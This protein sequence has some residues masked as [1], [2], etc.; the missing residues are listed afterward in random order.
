ML[1]QVTVEL[2]DR[3]NPESLLSKIAERA[4]ALVNA[5]HGFIFLSEGQLLVLRA[6][7]GGFAHNIGRSEPSPGS[8][9]L[10]QVWLSGESFAAENY[11]AW[12]FHDPDYDN[13]RLVAIAGVPIRAAGNMAGVLEVANTDHSRS[14]S[15][16]EIGILERFALLASLVLDNTQLFSG[17]Q[18]ELSERAQAEMQLRQANAQLETQMKQIKGLQMILREQAIRDPL[19]GLYNRRYLA[20][21][22]DREL[23]RAAREGYPVGFVMLDIDH[24][25][26]VNDR[27]GHEVGDLVLRRLS[28]LVQEQTRIGGI[29]CRY[30]GEEILSILPNTTA[31][32]AFQIAER[33]RLAFMGLDMS[34]EKGPVTVTIS[35]GIS[36][37]PVHGVA[38]NELIILA[39]KAM[40]QAKAAGRNRVVIWDSAS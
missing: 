21:T 3:P 25:K 24:F 31:E 38:A 5:Q 14:F 32:V 36:A 15:K 30:G 7:T 19:T 35:C 12:E 6:A 39:D 37:Y 8:G 34:C 11:S 13:E 28:S 1:H 18:S 33:W 16:A 27:F 23:S 4:S 29:I 17:L 9:V 40:Y 20:E 26:N 10:R 2:L 22:Q